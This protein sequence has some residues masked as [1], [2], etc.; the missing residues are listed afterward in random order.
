ML[1]KIENALMALLVTLALSLVTAEVVLRY[2][3][4]RYL[5]DYGL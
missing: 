4:P 2:F 5:T 1:R 3:F